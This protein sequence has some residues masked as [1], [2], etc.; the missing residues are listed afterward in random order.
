MLRV[1]SL[2]KEV[3][4]AGRRA[5]KP[6]IGGIGSQDV[7]HSTSLFPVFI[8]HSTNCSDFAHP[9]ADPL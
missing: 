3:F 2:A 5:I 6:Q 1:T 9:R 4:I 7:R 8:G